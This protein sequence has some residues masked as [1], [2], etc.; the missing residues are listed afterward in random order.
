MCLGPELA[1][2][3]QVVGTIATGAGA[4]YQVSAQADASK[5][6]KRAEALRKQQMQMEQQQ[7]QRESIRKYQMARATS[8]S[9]ISG[10]TGTLDNSAAGGA[11]SAYSASLGTQ[12]GELA[13]AGRIG[14]GM[15]EANADMSEAAGRS[16][17]GGAIGSF[18]KDLFQAG[19][20]IG[21]IGSTLWNGS[22]GGFTTS[23][24][25]VS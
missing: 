5:A 9:N 1:L 21:R 11:T 6:S 4:A 10:Q 16:A 24:E 12:T 20:A 22:E 7:K 18:G 14:E 25:K 17:I 3:A 2:A 8:L 15:F 23:Y 13:Q 19:P